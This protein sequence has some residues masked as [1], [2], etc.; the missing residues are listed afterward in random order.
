MNAPPRFTTSVSVNPYQ[1]E[2]CECETVIGCATSFRF[3]LPAWL[4]TAYRSGWVALADYP[5]SSNRPEARLHKAKRFGGRDRSPRGLRARTYNIGT[6][7]VL[8]CCWLDHERLSTNPLAR[9]RG[10]KCC[11]NLI[12]WNVNVLLFWFPIQFRC[13]QV[14]A[15]DYVYRPKIQPRAFCAVVEVQ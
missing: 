6:M 7:F 12:A 4:P 15:A 14:I 9:F 1:S 2:S 3:T 13:H 8:H 11:Q 5:V 10:R